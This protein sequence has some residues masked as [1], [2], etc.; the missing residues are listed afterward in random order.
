MKNHDLFFLDGGGESPLED[1]GRVCGQRPQADCPSC[2]QESTFSHQKKSL[3]RGYIK[4]LAERPQK[5]L[6][7]HQATPNSL[8]SRKWIFGG[9][10]RVKEEVYKSEGVWV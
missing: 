4:K 2:R 7:T 1:A 8:G 10:L 6:I 5:S 3:K 9:F